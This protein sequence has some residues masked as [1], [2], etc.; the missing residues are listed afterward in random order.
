MKTASGYGKMNSKKQLKEFIDFPHELYKSDLNYV[1]ELYV[2]QKELLWKGD[3]HPFYEHSSSKLFLARSNGKI[4]GRIAA[5]INTNHIAYVNK[6]E[7][8]FGFFDCLQFVFQGVQ[9]P[10]QLMMM[11]PY[12]FTLIVCLLNSKRATGPAGVGKHFDAK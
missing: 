6:Q 7:G 5:I 1:P 9:T 11:M 8:F 3:K 10:A 12:V 4:V 2:G